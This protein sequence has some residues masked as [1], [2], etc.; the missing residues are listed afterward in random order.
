VSDAALAHLGL[1]SVAMVGGRVQGRVFRLSFSGEL[2]Y[3]IAVPADAGDEVA[4]ALMEAGA[5]F[6]I[7]AYGVEAMNVLRI[8]KGHVTHNEINGTATAADVGMGR[9]VARKK[10]DFIGRAM[11]DREGLVAPDR[12]QLVGVA[13][14]DPAATFRAGAHILDKGAAARLENDQ[15]HITSACYSP[16]LGS[17][18]GLA[19]VKRGR[20]R[21]GE[22]VMVWN[23]LHG[24]YTPAR[25][26]APVFVD[27][28]NRRLHV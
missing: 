21:L 20:E 8:E 25:L 13:P 1:K 12:L 19:L 16:H 3:E 18:I 28:E 22:E 17:A 2:A 26:T 10:T 27:P 6:G 11:I 9:L 24:E 7:C 4:E 23:A 14:L 5:A 15:G